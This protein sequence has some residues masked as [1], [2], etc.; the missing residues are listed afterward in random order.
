MKVDLDQNPFE[1]LRASDYS[2]AEVIEYWVD[3]SAQQG[4]L[5]NILKP[6]LVM[7]MLLL[8]SKGSGKTHLM[9]YCSASV[10]ATLNGGDLSKAVT[11][12]GYIGIYIRTEGL[13]IHKFADKGQDL[14]SWSSVFG[15]YFELWLISNLLQTCAAL[16]PTDDQE[17]EAAFSQRVAALF[18]AEVGDHFCSVSSFAS[19]ISKAQRHIDYVVNNAAL[20]RSLADL[21]ITFSLGRLV[22]GIPEILSDLVPTL[23]GVLFVYLIDEA[24][25]LTEWQQRLVNTL[26]RYRRGN[27]TLK[28]GA[29]LYGIRT[30]ETLGSGEPIKRDAE[31]ERIELD[32]FLRE[33]DD[34]FG[35]FCRELIEKRLKLHNLPAIRGEAISIDG[36][37]KKLNSENYYQAE[38]LE[39][40]ST[41]DKAGRERPYFS[42]LRKE[43]EEAFDLRDSELDAVVNCFKF[44]DVPLIEKALLL[45]FY[46]DWPKSRDRV[47]KVAEQISRESEAILPAHKGSKSRAVKLLK[48]FDSDLLAQLFRDCQRR[49]PYAG[50]DTLIH[51]S[52]GAPRNLLA[53]LKH[54]YRRSS[55]AGERPFAGGVVSIESQS[56]GVMDSAAWFW[57]DAQPESY[58]TEVR[59][60]IEALAVLFRTIRYSE[61]PSECDL[62]TF[63]TTYSHLTPQSKRVVQTAENWSYLIRVKVDAKNRNSQQVDPKYQLAPMLAPKWGL[64]SHR[65]G[66]IELKPD[67]ANALFDHALGEGLLKAFTRRVADMRFD[68]F[69]RKRRDQSGPS[70]L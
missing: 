39:I 66:S 33:N 58:G 37:F 13:N 34:Q 25:N 50:L 59:E 31:Y 40:L 10:Q 65:R 42:K 38:T 6:R 9:R 7:P 3:I 20:T 27:A 61:R 43:L 67:L 62:C 52:Q 22:F 4:G 51:L 60:G 70:M 26:I 64:S 48:H 55:F 53:V 68:G 49:S 45:L 35:A 16:L 15:M 30:Y 32:S 17:F 47:A 69:G 44:H 1:S 14:E 8:G 12:G 2:D 24:E 56:Q 11:A 41:W 29:R 36:L 21:S 54:I 23:R 18:D 46:R 5:L 63:S 19:Y 57:E 28:I